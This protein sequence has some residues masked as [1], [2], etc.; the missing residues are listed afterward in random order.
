[1]YLPTKWKNSMGEHGHVPMKKLEARQ[2]WPL[3]LVSEGI[4][5]E[6]FSIVYKIINEL[7]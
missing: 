4:K 7:C 2:E 3:E 5:Y 1:M 6:L